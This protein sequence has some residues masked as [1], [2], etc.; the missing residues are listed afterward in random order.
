[1]SKHDK[2]IIALL[3]CMYYLV[4]LLEGCGYKGDYDFV[5]NTIEEAEKILKG[6]DD[7]SSI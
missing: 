2:I 5:W 1:M 4:G 7:G 6:E 3:E